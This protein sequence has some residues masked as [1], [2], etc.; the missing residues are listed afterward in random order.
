MA[1]Q[2][3]Q[4]GWTVNK[5]YGYISEITWS[6]DGDKHVAV[7][8]FT[9]KGGLFGPVELICTDESDEE[10]FLKIYKNLQVRVSIA[11]PIARRR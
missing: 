3:L 2:E 8:H 7:H 10:P 5:K 6:R 4:I 1:E 11:K 9:N